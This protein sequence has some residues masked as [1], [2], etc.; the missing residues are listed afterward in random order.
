MTK[1]EEEF[2]CLACGSMKGEGV[3]IED[4]RSSEYDAPLDGPK[5]ICI[6]T[7]CLINAYRASGLESFF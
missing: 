1:I 7:D 3:A 2:V 6:C 5:F 4:M